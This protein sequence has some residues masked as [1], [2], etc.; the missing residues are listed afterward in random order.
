MCLRAPE[1][2]TDLLGRG[3]SV[4]IT[5]DLFCKKGSQRVL[6]EDKTMLILISLLNK[7]TACLTC[8][9]RHGGLIDRLE[10]SFLKKE[11]TSL[12]M[13]IHVSNERH[14]GLMI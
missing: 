4:M 13:I 5:T 11:Q 10:V 9:S 14:L 8:C 6:L 12:V 1:E 2:S 7:L 3:E